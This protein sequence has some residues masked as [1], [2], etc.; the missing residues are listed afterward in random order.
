MEINKIILKAMIDKNIKGA[1]A[2][3]EHTGLSKDKC[4][5]MI[6]GD[7]TVRLIDVELVVSSLGLEVKFIK[8]GGE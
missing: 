7:K 5:R 3:S 8:S 2:L 4:Y 6:K 1:V